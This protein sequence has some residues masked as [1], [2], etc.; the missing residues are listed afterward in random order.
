MKQLILP[1]LFLLITSISGAQ[2]ETVVDP[3][4]ESVKQCLINNGT[5]DYYANVV[6]DMFMMLQKQYAEKNVPE[7][8]WIELKDI[9]TETLDE[10]SQMVVSAYRGHY[11]Q[12]DLNKMNTMFT[13][14]TGKKMFN[15]PKSLSEEDKFKVNE[16]Y[17]SEVGQKIMGS[18][19]SMNKI[20]SQVSEMWSS[21]LYQSVITKLDEKGF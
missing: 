18:Q 2:T 1:F 14:D 3:Y 12:D 11:S 15:D 19:E 8:V 21:D 9:K 17:N 7:S 13:T 10:L 16:F 5:R 4:S 20:M 6:D